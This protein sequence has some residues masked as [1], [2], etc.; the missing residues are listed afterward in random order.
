MNFKKF[1]EPPQKNLPLILVGDQGFY[2][3]HPPYVVLVREV[4]QRLSGFR[5]ALTGQFVVTH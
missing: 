1:L 2:L 3:V 5:I 4:I